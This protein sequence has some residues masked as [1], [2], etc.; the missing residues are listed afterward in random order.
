MDISFV[1]KEYML[2][3]KKKKKVYFRIVIHYDENSNST[4]VKNI[5]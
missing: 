5:S 2:I 3:N 1:S 4:T